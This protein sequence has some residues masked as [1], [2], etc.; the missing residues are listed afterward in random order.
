MRLL[1]VL[2]LLLA[3]VCLAPALLPGGGAGREAPVALVG[4]P[5]PADL[6]QVPCSDPRGCPDL[7][8]DW[9]KLAIQVQRTEHFE[10]S[11]CEV[12]DG[13]TQPG[14]RQLLRFVYN[15]PNYGPG[16]LEIG[17]PRDHPE[18]FVFAP[19]HNHYHF[20]E[21]ADYR[22]WKPL[23]FVAWNQARLDQPDATA[24]EVFA[25]HPELRSEFVA[26]LKTGFCVIDLYPALP[27]GLG[28]AV[29]DPRRF[30]SCSNNQGL[31]VGWADEYFVTTSGQYIDVTDVPTG[32][33]VLE[34]EVNAERLYEEADYTNNRA[35]L[36]TAIVAEL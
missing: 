16:W 17:A 6:D 2:S 30:Q 18:W 22:L 5:A 36:P 4:A 25:A 20:R 15:T 34:V 3:A 35:F 9:A 32:A 12:Q 23:G 33:Y 26:G 7:V 13:F 27:T 31:G 10:A 14:D 29:P 21:Y 19:C 11:S 8:L 1:R 24:A 28:V